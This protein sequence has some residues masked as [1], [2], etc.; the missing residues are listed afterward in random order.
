[1]FLGTSVGS[2]CFRVSSELKQDWLHAQQINGTV[3]FSDRT[4]EA[5]RN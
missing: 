3:S 4:N 5:T 1:M 2:I